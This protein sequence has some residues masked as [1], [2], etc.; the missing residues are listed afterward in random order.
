M[1][2]LRAQL[3][4]SN[5]AL[6]Q[7]KKIYQD[8]VGVAKVGGAEEVVPK[9]GADSGKGKERDDDSHYFESYAYNGTPFSKMRT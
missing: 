7:L 9:G 2:A 8:R 1:A 5:Q 4:D 6:E 3:S